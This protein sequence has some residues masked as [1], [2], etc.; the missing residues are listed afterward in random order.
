MNA[1]C[2]DCK[3]PGKLGN[4]IRIYVITSRNESLVVQDQEKKMCF[5]CYQIHKRTMQ[6]TH[7]IR[8]RNEK[9]D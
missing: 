9:S 2:E 8:D 6:V 4:D 3:K 1:S 5:P 7:K